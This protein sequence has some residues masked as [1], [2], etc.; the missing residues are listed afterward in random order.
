MN[1]LL[2]T[3]IMTA[4][5]AAFL[6]LPVN[7]HAAGLPGIGIITPVS[8]EEKTVL[9]SRLGILNDLEDDTVPASPLIAATSKAFYQA[10][11]KREKVSDLSLTYRKEPYAAEVRIPE[12][13]KDAFDA[14]DRLGIAKLE[15]DVV[16]LRHQ[17]KTKSEIMGFMSDGDC[18]E[19][20]A[21]YEFNLE[22][23]DPSD[24]ELWYKINTGDLYGV[25]VRGEYILTGEDALRY[26]LKNVQ[27]Y[28]TVTENIVNLRSTPDKSRSDNKIGSAYIGSC[29]KLTPDQP[30]DPNWY[31]IYVRDDAVA[32]IHASCAE[33]DYRLAEGWRIVYNLN[34]NTRRDIVEYAK[35]FEGNPYVWNGESLTNGCDCSG[36]VMCL[37]RDITGIELPHYSGS[38]SERGRRI[39]ADELQP[40]DLIFYDSMGENRISHVS[41]YIGDG[42][43]IH[44]FNSRVGIVITRYDVIEP[45]CFTNIIDYPYEFLY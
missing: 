12:K 31:K 30:I 28:A 27:Q 10:M 4:L 26:A 13:Y 14:F 32:Y 6:L 18:C 44:A 33:L 38:Q 7:S 11:M 8:H 23:D 39:S 45:W 24:D 5:A 42:M 29:Y 9:T 21:A 15:S 37:Y 43:C 16:N 19:I 20:V 34:E 3:G 35:Q 2:R 17:A 1:K 25:Y 22:N 36:Y 40:G 41:M